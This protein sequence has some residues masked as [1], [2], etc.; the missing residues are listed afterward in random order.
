M[1]ELF[2]LKPRL[3]NFCCYLFC[4]SFGLLGMQNYLKNTRRTLT[5]RAKTKF[6]PCCVVL[7]NVS[8]TENNLFLGSF[9]GVHCSK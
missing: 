1:R 8:L 6:H 2:P 5:F 7:L 3:Y 4:V 9:A